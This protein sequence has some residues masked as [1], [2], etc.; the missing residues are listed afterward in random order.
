[1]LKTFQIPKQTFVLEN[2]KELFLKNC[3]QNY[4]LKT[5]FKRI[6]GIQT[7]KP[8]LVIELPKKTQRFIFHKI[9]IE[10]SKD[11]R[12]TIQPRALSPFESDKALHTSSL[13]KGTFNPLVSSPFKAFERHTLDARFPHPQIR[14]WIMKSLGHPFP[15]L[16]LLIEPYLINFGLA[17]K[18]S[19]SMPLTVL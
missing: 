6:L 17:Q 16:I 7:Y 19:S 18:V 9:L 5:I 12:E 11:R 15:Y 1:M 10:M 13:E 14:Q 8:F 3:S 2:I 4:F